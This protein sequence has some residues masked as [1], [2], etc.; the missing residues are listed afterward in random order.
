MWWTFIEIRGKIITPLSITHK[1]YN[2]TLKIPVSDNN[3]FIVRD[4]QAYQ[5]QIRMSI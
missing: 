2:Q 3:N 1:F 4:V 5:P